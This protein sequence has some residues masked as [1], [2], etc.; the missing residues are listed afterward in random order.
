MTINVGVPEIRWGQ[1]ARVDR[2]NTLNAPGGTG[3]HWTLPFGGCGNHYAKTGDDQKNIN[4]DLEQSVNFW[5]TIRTGS[6]GYN[7]RE[8]ATGIDRGFGVYTVP[9]G[10][11]WLYVW[12]TSYD[13]S[14]YMYLRDKMFS[15]GYYRGFFGNTFQLGDTNGIK[16]VDGV[17]VLHNALNAN[18]RLTSANN[19]YKLDNTYLLSDRRSGT[20]Y[21]LQNTATGKALFSTTASMAGHTL[22]GTVP[23]PAKT[24]MAINPSIATANGI[25]HV[26]WEDSRNNHSQIYYKR[27]YTANQLSASTPPQTVIF[28]GSRL[29]NLTDLRLVSPKA[30]VSGVPVLQT[31][32]PEFVWRVP[33]ASMT[34]NTRFKLELYRGVTDNEEGLPTFNVAHGFQESYQTVAVPAGTYQLSG[35]T[36]RFTPDIYDALGKTELNEVYR[37]QV[38]VDYAGTDLWQSSL[39]SEVFQLDPPLSIDAPINYPNPFQDSTF[40]RYKLSKDASSVY[41][42][43]FDLAGRLVRVLEDAP[44]AG[45]RPFRE[46]NEVRWDG[47]NGVGDVVLNGVYVY[48][49]TATDD[50]GTKVTVRGKAV[51][52]K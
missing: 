37:W 2:T 34:A 50:A 17:V 15:A 21:L 49:I 20:L 23:M 51:K 41:V 8:L 4:L 24:G 35:D 31:A 5:H 26:V 43:L 16:D 30:S 29:Q 13:N 33:T 52:L 6:W 48:T 7:F 10:A 14:N 27:F 46:Y 25:I 9:S 12:V 38:W 42:R 47:R 45:T 11:Y 44:T 18:P 28:S 36:V 3:C 1:G 19:L 39:T 22:L 32:A 40:I